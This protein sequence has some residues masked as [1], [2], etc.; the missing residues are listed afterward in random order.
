MKRE[1]EEP[2]RHLLTSSLLVL[3]LRNLGESIRNYDVFIT[4]WFV[5]LPLDVA[6]VVRS[7]LPIEYGMDDAQNRE[8]M[9]ICIL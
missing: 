5:A 7:V 3:E 1:A 9:D 6:A 2:A 8:A 4:G